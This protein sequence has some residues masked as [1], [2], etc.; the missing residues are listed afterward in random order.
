MKP[1]IEGFFDFFLSEVSDGA[2]VDADRN[3]RSVRNV[4]T[5][6]KRLR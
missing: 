3:V 5:V 6:G 2:N 4:G 1:G